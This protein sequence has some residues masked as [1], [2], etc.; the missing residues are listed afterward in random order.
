MIIDWHSHVYP[1][2]E[3]AIPFWQG[4]CPMTL[5]NGLEAM[6]R[7]GIDRNCISNPYHELA[8]AE[9]AEQLKRIRRMNEYLAGLAERH[10]GKLIGFATAVPCGGDEFAR[11]VERGVTQLGL[12]GVI[13]M[14][15]L[16]GAYPDD[17]AALPFWETVH[18]LDVPVMIHP[19]AVAFGEERL[20]DYRLASS[21]GRPA[22]NMLALSRLIVRGI[23]ERFPDL[24]LVGSHLA[25]GLC[26]VIG[27]MDYAYELQDEAF[28]LGKYEPMLI[29]RKPSEYL[30]MMYLDCT[31][32]HAPAVKCAIETVG[33]DHVL[34]GT[35][36]PPLTPLKSRG[37]RLVQGL[38]IPDAD[39]K[40]ILA[41]NAQRLLKL[42]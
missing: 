20:K 37:L 16:K 4:R 29:R 27:R 30:K 22:D 11:E 39:R 28:F 24:K 14:S 2:E 32:Y 3:Q 36:A 17:D 18:R 38:D 13:A 5:E 40:K 9:P 21:I 19:P 1:P 33:A 31:S 41:G 8:Y 26:E 42:H 23:F 25:G 7:C 35:D 10:S 12:R 34:F 6:D 15:S